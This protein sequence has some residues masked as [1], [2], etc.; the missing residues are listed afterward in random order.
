MEI[1]DNSTTYLI[2][3][4]I[5]TSSNTRFRASDVD[6]FMDRDVLPKTTI[7]INYGWRRSII[8]R[9]FRFTSRRIVEC[10]AV[11]SI[12]FSRSIIITSFRR[13]SNH[14]QISHIFR[15]AINNDTIR[16][17]ER[18]TSSTTY[19]ARRNFKL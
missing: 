9:Q 6:G 4:I 18:V 19:A 5:E 15:L 11:F 16:H 14:K 8:R 13:A 2:S 7:T 10:Y 3:S 17:D 12:F 1:Y